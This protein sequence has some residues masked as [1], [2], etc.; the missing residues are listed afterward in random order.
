MKSISQ[1]TIKTYINIYSKV[2]LSSDN[3]AFLFVFS[4]AAYFSD[5]LTGVF[6]S[7]LFLF[8]LQITRE[9]EEV[10]FSQKQFHSLQLYHALSWEAWGHGNDTVTIVSQGTQ[11][12]GKASQ[13]SGHT[14]SPA[15]YLLTWSLKAA[16]Y[17]SVIYSTIL[18]SLCMSWWV[19][20]AFIS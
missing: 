18:K 2:L 6:F 15:F 16:W 12:K 17:R 1:K 14:S 7:V 5:Q 4:V 13:Q 8:T 20:S 19:C 11:V 3:N 9:E 10:L